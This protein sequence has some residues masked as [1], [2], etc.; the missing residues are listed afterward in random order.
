LAGGYEGVRV[1]EAAEVFAVVAGFQVVQVGFPVT[2]IAT[3]AEGVQLVQHG[4]GGIGGHDVVAQAIALEDVMH[5]DC[6]ALVQNGHHIALDV[7][8]VIVSYAVTGHLCRY[9][10]PSERCRSWYPRWS[11]PSDTCCRR[12]SKAEDGESFY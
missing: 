9:R 2:D 4:S 11:W 6:A 10:W 3:V 7:D 12:Y 1:E 8:G 5:H